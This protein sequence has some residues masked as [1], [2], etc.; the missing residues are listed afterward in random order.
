MK[1]EPSFATESCVLP[2]RGVSGGIGGGG[3]RR[4]CGGG[5]GPPSR[6]RRTAASAAARGPP[7]NTPSL[8]HSL[9][10][11]GTNTHALLK[12]ESFCAMWKS[13]YHM[14][15]DSPPQSNK[16]VGGGHVRM[17]VVSPIRPTEERWDIE[18]TAK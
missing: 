3:G 8:T 2:L 13:N 18:E 15:M 16:S 11:M 9:N 4:T 10:A 14:N 12:Y 5:G 1:V 6:R 17:S 7:S